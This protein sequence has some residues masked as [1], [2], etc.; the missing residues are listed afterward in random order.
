MTPSLGP[1]DAW[2]QY[3]AKLPDMPDN[4]Y[5]AAR[6]SF[7]RSTIA[8][9][10]AAQG[11]DITTA[12]EA[13]MQ[14]S[15]RTGKARFP[16]AEVAGRTAIETA[17]APLVGPFDRVPQPQDWEVDKKPFMGPQQSLG[18]MLEQPVQSAMQEN[19]RQGNSNL[20]PQMVGAGIGSLPYVIP[21]I[22]GGSALGLS[23]PLAN[24]AG[25]A[26]AQGAMDSAKA[27][28]G[29]RLIKGMQGAAEGALAG[30]L[31]EAIP[32][33]R[34]WMK[35]SSVA[36]AVERSIRNVA[37]P[38]EEQT[39]AA[40]ATI[41][42][43]LPEAA[44]EQNAKDV[45][46]ATKLGVP[47]N[48]PQVQV[49]GA[50]MVSMT[51]KIGQKVQVPPAQALAYLK[52]EASIEDILGSAK[53]IHE[54]TS[55]IDTANSKNGA[56]DVPMVLAGEKPTPR[57]QPLTSG[58]EAEKSVPP[59]GVELSTP[60]VTPSVFSQWSGDAMERMLQERVLDPSI[61][62][63]PRSAAMTRL[64]ALNPQAWN[65]VKP[66]LN[67]S[68]QG[69]GSV[70]VR[71]YKVEEPDFFTRISAVM[72]V[73]GQV[74]VQ[75]LSRKL[76]MTYDEGVKYLAEAQAAGVIEPIA[77]GSSS[78]IYRFIPRKVTMD[79]V[80]DYDFLSTT[81]DGK[82][83]N[84]KTGQVFDSIDQALGPKRV[85]M[86]QE[87]PGIDTLLQRLK[88]KLKEKYPGIEFPS[89]QPE[90]QPAEPNLEQQLNDSVNIAQRPAWQRESGTEYGQASLL[91]F[92]PFEKLSK[93][94]F[95]ELWIEA[96]NGD[97]T[98]GGKFYD[99]NIKNASMDQMQAGTQQQRP[100]WN[101]FSKNQG[102]EGAGAQTWP[103]VGGAQGIRPSIETP[104]GGK[105]TRA[106]WWHETHHALIS[107]A[108][109]DG[110]VHEI[111]GSDPV[112]A[113]LTDAWHPEVRDFY[114]E[115]TPQVIPEEIFTW[116]STAYRSGDV[117]M[118]EE[119]AKA[120]SGYEEL[121]KW[122]TGNVQKLMEYTSGTPD[123][124][125]KRRLMTRLGDLINRSG[126][127]LED[128]SK[129][130]SVLGGRV[131][132]V[133]ETQNFALHTDSG[134]TYFDSRE[135]LA[136]HLRDN[137]S[138]S[139]IAPE[140]LDLTGL[141]KGTPLYAAKAPGNRAPIHTQPPPPDLIPG[142]DKPAGMHVMSYYF[143]PFY[144]WVD[145]VAEKFAWPELSKTMRA[146]QD[147]EVT[148]NNGMREPLST[149][150]DT[151]GKVPQNRQSL[152]F[153]LMEALPQD[154]TA[155][156][157]KLG[158][159]PKEIDAF[160][161]FNEK[162]TEPLESELGNVSLEHFIRK[163][164][165]PGSRN[166]DTISA[167]GQYN[168]ASTSEIKFMGDSLRTGELDPRDQNL[169]NIAAEYLRAGM[170]KKYM[171]QPLIDAGRLVNA[172]G[173]DKVYVAGNLQPLLARHINYLRGIPDYG[174][175][176]VHETIQAA[177]TQIN[178]GLKQANKVLPESMRLDPLENP[179]EAM[180]KW[181]TYSYAGALMLRVMVPLRDSLQYFITTFPVLGAKYSMR[182]ISRMFEASSNP[183]EILGIPKQYGAMLEDRDMLKYVSGEDKPDVTRL[184][185]GVSAGMHVMQLSN[186]IN[187][188]ASFW[189]HAERVQD[190]LKD[191]GTDLSLDRETFA[192]RAG[193]NYLTKTQRQNYLDQLITLTPD[194]QADYSYRAAKD[195]VD[196]SQWNYSRGS[197]PGFYKYGLG[198]LFGQY[199]TWPLNYLEYARNITGLGGSS[200]TAGEK[201]QTL[202]RLALAHTAILTAGDAMGVDT[203]SWV[204]TNPI[205]YGGGPMFNAVTALPQTLDFESQK[206][207]DARRTVIR[208]IWP[209]G[210]PGGLFAE[211]VYKG[212]KRD[213]PDLWKTILGFHPM[214]PSE[215][216]RGLHL[217]PSTLLGEDQQR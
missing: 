5:D 122:Y 173:E 114:N 198:K 27:Q 32:A 47:K 142:V 7:F 117:P 98:S 97:A 65:D 111:F 108:E 171:E 33:I 180:R 44:L 55:A 8:P 96:G 40:A 163:Y 182:G 109:V 106:M 62:E 158:I 186:N 69:W 210:V 214:Q 213:D 126:G 105:V 20:L 79:Q 133:P 57:P 155:V 217:I 127:S 209:M 64:K 112:T 205:A 172:V 84:I 23:K 194:R 124:V 110:A 17:L 154:R 31:F 89:E 49:S 139:M 178:K 151:I 101:T 11:H 181:I 86:N 204:F 13:F 83:K 67:Q 147:A 135:K 30:T 100:L 14:S 191:L 93:E 59:E 129:D 125:Y 78:P 95:S 99:W 54:T 199:G 102:I 107:G 208:P 38:E 137:Y 75:T 82:I 145:S 50:P 74:S 146:V 51:L 68:P 162:F 88:D 1:L 4:A 19:T 34:G 201:V 192:S 202:T 29:Q 195:L 174:T 60:S 136:D 25:F 76:G 160:T 161:E 185:K 156:A 168:R 35:Q 2:D 144:N 189:G 138:P 177:M 200:L 149:I 188:L 9:W 28:D 46:A 141:P 103:A 153:K 42:P 39:A 121:A 6:D 179:A 166:L 215:H 77:Q 15:E 80:P 87:G 167:E 165:G 212:I 81:E 10:A 113:T 130:P 24:I 72:S 92:T 183:D 37:T 18:S 48:P 70:G 131:D 164:Q 71:P 116:L 134:T 36:D 26:V 41:S 56:Y 63:S 152:L 176:I 91:N 119:F 58:F 94:E 143:R 73:K 115:K 16:R 148:M 184:E 132:F 207:A 118:I 216:G 140:M 3:A 12:R 53:E 85:A 170:R 206:G 90:V 150:K 169:T 66:Y 193:L 203:A 45:Q 123:S 196:V 61:G 157:E 187:R 211:Q 22:A 43:K 120:D 190:T 175:R 104:L 159:T 52:G 128:M 197:A 21:A